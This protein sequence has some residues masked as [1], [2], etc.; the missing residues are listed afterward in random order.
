MTPLAP[1]PDVLRGLRLFAGL[2]AA[3]LAETV[4][5]AQTQRVEKGATIFSQGDPA[6]LCHALID[7]RVKIVQT[8]ADG[9]QMVVRYIG[10]GEMFGTAAVF[11]G[12]VYPADALAVAD[13]VAIHWS[14][15][16]MGVLMERHPRVAMNA[17]D[18]VGRRLQE[19]QT[20]LRE[21]S[22]ERVERRVAHALLR[23][24]RQA[25]RRVEGG[26][27]IDFPLSRQDIAEMTGTTLH[28]VSRILSGWEA[29]GIV[30]GGRQ[31]V[32][33]RRPHALVAIAE[34]LPRP[35]PPA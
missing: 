10:P 24:A 3:A 6:T 35:L 32:T 16:A 11:A 20:R 13:C 17:L 2:D 30:E 34:D 7:G 23:L 5:S 29:Q 9:Q 31:Q 26:V 12:G 4:R 18:I 1:D 14:A 22:T 21:V 15:A 8:G 19:V 33:I 28:T 27:E 25:G